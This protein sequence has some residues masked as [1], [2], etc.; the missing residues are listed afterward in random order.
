MVENS[1][2]FLFNFRFMLKT[3]LLLL[4][5][6]LP[7]GLLAQAS[8]STNIAFKLFDAEKK[9]VDWAHFKG[10]YILVDVQGLVVP[11]DKLDQFMH[12]DEKSN[13]FI[14]E[15]NTIGPRFSFAIRHKQKQMVIYLPFKNNFSYYALDLELKE[16][17]YLLDFDKD[18]KEKIYLNSNMPYYRIEHIQWKKQ[19]KRFQQS[20]YVQDKTYT[21]H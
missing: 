19:K 14:L 4:Y 6:I 16:G 3:N 1:R 18:G 15:I 17:Q 7:F 12:Y 21:T 2:P 20:V 10:D 9:L 5:L 8:W 13:Y 11:N